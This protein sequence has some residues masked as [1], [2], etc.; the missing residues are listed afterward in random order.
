LSDHFGSEEEHYR[1]E[2][3]IVAVIEGIVP[4]VSDT[5]AVIEGMV[6][7]VSDMVAVIEGIVPLLGIALVEALLL[8]TVMVVVTHPPVTS[9]EPKASMDTVCR[10]DTLDEMLFFSMFRT[11]IGMF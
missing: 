4:V 11:R 1:L 5:V 7:A 3:D 8:S 2:S 10:N 6:P 9:M